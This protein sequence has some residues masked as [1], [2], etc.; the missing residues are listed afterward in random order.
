MSKVASLPH[1]HSGVADVGGVV[2]AD[3]PALW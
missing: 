1:H 3:V 2:E